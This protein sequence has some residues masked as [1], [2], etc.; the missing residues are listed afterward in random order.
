MNRDPRLSE[1]LLELIKSRLLGTPVGL[2]LNI[3]HQVS[4]DGILSLFMPF[5]T[6][7]VTVGDIVHGGVIATLA[8]IAGVS[9]AVWACRRIPSGGATTNLTI[10]YLAPAKGKELCATT[11]V[12]RAGSRQTVCRVA[13]FDEV[14][15]VEALLTIVLYD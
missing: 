14:L 15:I 3:R 7:N 8:D 13:I 12:L 9:A 6:E 2:R 4:G 5:D 10:N 11:T 1:A